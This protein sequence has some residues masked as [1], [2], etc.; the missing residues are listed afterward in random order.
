MSK[1]GARKT[2]EQ[3][4]G[5]QQKQRRKPSTSVI[6]KVDR[7]HS[8]DE[9]RIYRSL[10]VGMEQGVIVYDAEGRPVMAN[11]VAAQILG[12]PMEQL[13]QRTPSDPAWRML[14]EDGTPFPVDALP[15]V[16]SLRSGQLQAGIVVGVLNPKEKAYRWLLMNVIPSHPSRA[17]RPDFVLMV[18]HDCTNEHQHLDILRSSEAQARS[19]LEELEAIFEVIADHVS[20]YDCNM[21]ILHMGRVLREALEL[22]EENLPESLDILVKDQS[23]ILD[24]HGEPLPRDQWPT[25]RILRGE[26][27]KDANAVDIVVQRAEKHDVRFSITGAPLFDQYGHITGA[28]TISMDVTRR[29]MLEQR[30]QNALH[31]ILSMAEA[32]VEERHDTGSLIAAFSEGENA[33]SVD[34]VRRRLAE[35]PYHLLDCERVALLLLDPE[36]QTLEPMIIVGA[37]PE[38]ELQWRNRMQDITL[39]DIVMGNEALLKQLYQGEVI[40]LRPG[41]SALKGSSLYRVVSPIMQGKQLIGLLVIGY[42]TLKVRLEPDDLS[43]IQGIGRLAALLIAREKAQQERDQALQALRDANEELER[44]NRMKSNFVSIVSH[45]FRTALTGIQGFSEIM[46]DSELS[47]MEVKEYAADIHADARRLVRMINNMLDLDRLE[48]GRLRLNLGWLDLN[49]IIIEVVNRLRQSA[50]KH[51]IRLRLAKALPIILGD[52]DKLTQVV[53]NLLNNAIKYSPGGGEI[54]IGSI[55]EGSMIHVYVKDNGLG[56]PDDELERIFERYTR[57]ETMGTRFIQGTGLGLPIVKEIVQ[58]HGGEVWAESAVG[59]GS[60]FHFTVRYGPKSV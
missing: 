8:Q 52:R 53:V 11:P 21:H 1:E 54:V 22:P 49:A 7:I 47:A 23:R 45:E 40:G 2:G 14:Q 44:L 29:R 25:A 13:M 5:E 41:A 4:T 30:T 3:K 50:P 33:E 19:R 16:R 55:L 18:F 12:I 10:F 37:S 51:H 46:R 28:V 27:L 58:L 31:A 56:I 43:I 15:V 17:T 38:Q 34:M 6:E 60:V 42:A 48:S 39:H 32:M 57:V 20:V 26:V 24:E 59:E 36:A 9:L 35:I